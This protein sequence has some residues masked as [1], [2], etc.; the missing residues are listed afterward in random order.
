MFENDNLLW[1]LESHLESEQLEAA[2]VEGDEVSVTTENKLRAMSVADGLEKG[3]AV[4]NE[5]CQLRN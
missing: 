5:T 1:L 4:V 2:D 3:E